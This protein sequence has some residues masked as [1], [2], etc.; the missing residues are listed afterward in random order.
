M[1]GGVVVPFLSNQDNNKRSARSE[2]F[3]W[4][5]PLLGPG[6]GPN[7]A[8]RRTLREAKDSP[9]PNKNLDRKKGGASLLD[10]SFK[11]GLLSL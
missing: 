9:R 7:I 4:G 6:E 11:R 3:E 2:N 5:K 1:G 8:T 10:F